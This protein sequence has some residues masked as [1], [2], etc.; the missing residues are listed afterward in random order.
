MDE[1]IFSKSDDKACFVRLST[2]FY[3]KIREKLIKG[4][5]ID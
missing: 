2:G 5:I 4:G 3:R 1:I